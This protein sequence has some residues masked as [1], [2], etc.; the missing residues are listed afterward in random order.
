MSKKLCSDTSKVVINM[1]EKRDTS[2]ELSDLSSNKRQK[3]PCDNRYL[4]IKD[5][6]VVAC[7]V[8]PV[9]MFCI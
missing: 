4:M 5:K 8:L 7:D 9:A 2:F 6:E 3:L 1:L